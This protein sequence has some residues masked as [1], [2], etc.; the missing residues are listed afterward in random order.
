[1]HYFLLFTI[2]KQIIPLKTNLFSSHSK[3]TQFSI[4]FI[5]IFQLIHSKLTKKN[6]YFYFIHHIHYTHTTYGMK[7]N[8]EMK[9]ASVCY[10][11]EQMKKV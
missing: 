2:R 5:D 10:I 7:N 11:F 3:S 8:N 6:I 1:M 4:H 9:K